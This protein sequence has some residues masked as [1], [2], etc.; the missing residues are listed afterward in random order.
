[1]RSIVLTSL[2]MVLVAALAGCRGDGASSGV[3]ARTACAK[4]VSLCQGNDQDRRDCEQA[5]NDLRPSVDPENAA[6]TARCVAEAR[7][8]GEAT[9]CM[10]GGAA[11]AGA[12]FLRDFTN[13]LT[14]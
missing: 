5:F 14:R 8:C 4:V 7:T 9:G 13:G 1:M 12:N 3:P 11:R 2:W 6:R 10:A